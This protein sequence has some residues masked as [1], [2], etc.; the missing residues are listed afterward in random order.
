VLL[1]YPEFPITM[2]PLAALAGGIAVGALVYSLAY[3]NGVAPER[4]ALAGIAVS[5]VLAA[6]TSYLLLKY[7]MQANAAM[8]WLAGGL[9][10]RDMTHVAAL[11]P[12]AAGALGLAWLLAPKVDVLRLGDEVARGLG[13][14]VEATRLG[15]VAVATLLAAGAVAVAGPIGFVG[16]VVPHVVLLLVPGAPYRIV[17]PGVA[18]MGAA[19]VVLADAAGRT[20]LAPNEVPAG[21]VT[22]LLGA[23]YFL[24]LLRRA[25]T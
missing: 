1:A 18:L 17:L 7:S 20:L 14:R 8:V 11:A 16:L 21:I 22:A 4:L 6:G 19:L 24:Y 12:W 3:R 23:P 5:A 10:G 2:L 13:M 9:W 15:L 25:I